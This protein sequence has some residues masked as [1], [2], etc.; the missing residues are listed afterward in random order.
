M[1]RRICVIGCLLG[2]CGVVTVASAE[3]ESPKQPKAKSAVIGNPT[4]PLPPAMERGTEQQP[5]FVRGDVSTHPVLQKTI[6][7]RETERRKEENDAALTLWTKVL[8]WLTFILALIAGIQAYL[9]VRQLK[10]TQRALDDS[11]EAANAAQL[12]A[13]AAK[14]SADALPKIERAYLFV[15][16]RFDTKYET[17]YQARPD[18]RYEATIEVVITN[19]GK[20][21]A[22]LTRLRAYAYTQEIAPTEL[23][24]HA[25]ADNKIPKG[26][27]VGAGHQWIYPIPSIVTREHYDDLTDVVNRIYCLGAIDYDDVL[28]IHRSTGFCWQSYPEDD[29]VKFTIAPVD[30]LNNFS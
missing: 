14:A 5:M 23:I 2:M 22:I 7:E 4:P 29:K 26:I 15:E 3:K 9:F 21:P 17:P 1:I 18:G 11:K 8:A 20:T 28:G 13:D 10:V 6:E 24:D 25:R 30:L 19:H 12:S 16:V 27:V